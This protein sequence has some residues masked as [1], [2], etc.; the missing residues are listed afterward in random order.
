MNELEYFIHEWED[1]TSMYD[2]EGYYV[3]GGEYYARTY[4][5]WVPLSLQDNEQAIEDYIEANADNKSVW[6]NREE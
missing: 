5:I 2:P 1:E 3:P 4:R 6:I